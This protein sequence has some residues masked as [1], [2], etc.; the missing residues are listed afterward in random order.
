MIPAVLPCVRQTWHRVGAHIFVEFMVKWTE[1]D[2]VSGCQKYFP[3]EVT[4]KLVL[5][6]DEEWQWREKRRYAKQKRRQTVKQG[7]PEY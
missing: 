3:M 1:F 7:L 2:S 5:K 6:D 4:V